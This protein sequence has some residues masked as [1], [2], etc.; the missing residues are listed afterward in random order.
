MKWLNIELFY[1]QLNKLKPG[2]ENGTEVTLIL[3]WN[4]VGRSNDE[5]N[6]SHEL[7]LTIPQV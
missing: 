6:F 3:S 1:S 2:I 4:V 7:L 5:T